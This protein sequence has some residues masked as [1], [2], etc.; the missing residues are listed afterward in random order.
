MDVSLWQIAL[1]PLLT[2]PLVL[3]FRFTGCASFG[4]ADLPPEQNPPGQQPNPTPTPTPTPTPNPNP[5]P[6]PGDPPPNYRKYILGETPNPGTVKNGGVQVDP[7][8]VIGYW[9]L[10]DAA[11]SNQATDEK[12]TRHGLYVPVATGLPVINPAGAQGGSEAAPGTILTGQPG[13]VASDPAALCRNYNGGYVQIPYSP[14]LYTDEFT[15]EAWVNVAG[16]RTDFE[17]FLVDTGGRYAVPPAGTLDRGF[18]LFADRNG[19]WQVRLAANQTGLFAAPPKVPLG[20]RT[21]VALVV[22]KNAANADTRDFTLYIDGKQAAT[23]AGVAYALPENAPLFIAVEN[24]AAQP[25]Q[26]VVPRRPFLALIQ[27]VVL[28]NKPLSVQEIENHVDINR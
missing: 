11:S 13:L 3:L 1:V 18:R 20:K 2:L 28:H 16:L 21:H 24:T 8:A 15:I 25:T 9:R 27:E 19:G 6:T 4:S 10:V 14:G 22:Q 26:A 17:H 5:T 12:A 7:K 23:K